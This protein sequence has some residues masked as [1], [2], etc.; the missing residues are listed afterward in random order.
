MCC[1]AAVVWHVSIG[2]I[3]GWVVEKAGVGGCETEV[4]V[5]PSVLCGRVMCACATTRALL[6]SEP[7][8]ECWELVLQQLW[9]RV[10]AVCRCTHDT[11]GGLSINESVVGGVGMATTDGCSTELLIGSVFMALQKV[12]YHI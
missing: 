11:A 8:S 9:T 12:L 7:T 6:S 1:A 5:S 3:M 4:C 2:G 10:A